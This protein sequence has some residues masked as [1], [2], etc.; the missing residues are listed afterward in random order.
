M[1][2]THFLEKV[3]PHIAITRKHVCKIV[4]IDVLGT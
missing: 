4:I 2:G 1:G 3:D